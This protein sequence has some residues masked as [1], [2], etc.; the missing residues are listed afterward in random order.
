[1]R[2]W[3]TKGRLFRT[4]LTTLLDLK[5]SRSGKYTDLT[6]SKSTSLPN[7]DA[8]I[9]PTKTSPNRHFC[10]TMILKNSEPGTM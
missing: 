10:Q 6:L 3:L 4:L 8:A 1:M 7:A 9:Q 5:L 2:I